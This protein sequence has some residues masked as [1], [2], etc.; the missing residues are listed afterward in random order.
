M[1]CRLSTVNKKIFFQQVSFF[2]F[3]LFLAFSTFSGIFL[4]CKISHN[5]LKKGKPNP[6]LS[7]EWEKWEKVE[8]AISVTFLIFM[9]MFRLSNTSSI[10]FFNPDELR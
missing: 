2:F 5:D 3:K 4:Q 10:I 8:V 6:N 1:S 9:V 7:F